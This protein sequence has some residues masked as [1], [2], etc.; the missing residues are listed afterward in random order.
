MRDL[1][2]TCSETLPEV[3]LIR[4]RNVKKKKRGD[5]FQESRPRGSS[6]AGPTSKSGDLWAATASISCR[7]ETKVVGRTS[8]TYRFPCLH[9]DIEPLGRRESRVDGRPRGLEG[10]HSCRRRARQATFAVGPHHE[11]IGGWGHEAVQMTPRATR[12]SY[13]RLP[14]SERFTEPGAIVAW[15]L[16]RAARW[17]PSVSAER[18][19]SNRPVVH[20][21]PRRGTDAPGHATAAAASCIIDCARTTDCARAKSAWA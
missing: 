14:Q 12:S 18:C 13:L 10:R 2:R 4:V 9:V 15:V 6:G 1:L 3:V 5:L 16:A 20:A 11:K 19:A 7:E 8:S 21:S 17:R